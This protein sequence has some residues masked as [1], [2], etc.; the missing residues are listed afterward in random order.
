LLTIPS[1]MSFKWKKVYDIWFITFPIGHNQLRLIVDHLTSNFLVLKEKNLSNKTRRGVDIICMEEAPTPRKYEM[2]MTGQRD[3]ISHGKSVLTVKFFFWVFVVSF[4]YH[5]QFLV[6]LF[7]YISFYFLICLF[8]F[9][10]CISFFFPCR[11]N[12]VDK[13]LKA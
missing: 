11:Y 8:I 10:S 2:E 6:F 7:P 5:F 12:Q 9:L 3:P 1:Q 13:H 4:F